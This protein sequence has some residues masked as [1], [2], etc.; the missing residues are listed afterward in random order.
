VKVVK[1]LGLKEISSLI[2]L[3][4]NPDCGAKSV[5][6]EYFKINP[7]VLRDFYPDLSPAFRGPGEAKLPCREMWARRGKGERMG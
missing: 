7:C 4:K 2:V 6:R 1:F 5:R 3:N